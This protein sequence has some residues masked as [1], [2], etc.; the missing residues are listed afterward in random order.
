[1][2]EYPSKEHFYR[3]TLAAGER[4][5]DSTACAALLSFLFWLCYESEAPA[6]R[7]SLLFFRSLVLLSL[8]LS[9]SF[10]PFTL[11][12]IPSPCLP[13][14]SL[15]FNIR[16]NK[17]GFKSNLVFFSILL[18]FFS[19]PP[20]LPLSESHWLTAGGGLA[21]Q[22]PPEIPLRLLISHLIVSSSQGIS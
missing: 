8:P 19:P 6:A 2:F 9:L 15:I 11:F 1:M 16:K 13:P 17:K 3:N 21:L 18:H 20:P 10:N 22:A 7:L 4:L 5:L 14:Y 12:Q